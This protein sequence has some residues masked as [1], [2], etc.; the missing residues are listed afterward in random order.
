M[1]RLLILPLAVVAALAVAAAIGAANTTVQITKNGFTPG[2]ITVT[3][4][5]TVTW[6][7]ADTKTHQVVAD[8]GTFASPTLAPNASWSFTPTKSGTL[9]YRD[10][11]A[12]SHKGTLKVDAPPASLTLGASL[13]TVIYGSATQLNGQ[14]S[15]QLANQPVTLTAQAY[16]KS[17]QSVQSTTTQSS[18]T[19]IFGITPTI[20]TTYTAHYTA[21]NSPAVTVNVAPRVGF[22]HSGSLFIAKVTSDIGYA[23]HY[24]ILQKRQTNGTWYSFKH[25]YLGDQ[26]RATFKIAVPK[27]HYTLR[28]LLPAGQAGA[29]YVASASRLLPIVRG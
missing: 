28:L 17:A 24:V 12:T 4:G 26:N 21:S 25:V 5:D 19:F 15:N 27:G 10:A 18:G 8:N 13:Q 6:H 11:Y 20:S 9:T 23:G 3:A 1:K 29:G 2:T 7:N 22:G 16:G 14:V